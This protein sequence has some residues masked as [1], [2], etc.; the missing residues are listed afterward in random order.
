MNIWLTES[1]LDG[2]V[3]PGVPRRGEVGFDMPSEAETAYL[4][5]DLAAF[6]SDTAVFEVDL[7][8]GAQS[9]TAPAAVS[10]SDPLAVGDPVSNGEL[11]FVL[12]AVSFPPWADST[13][14]PRKGRGS[15]C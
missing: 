11:R 14:R 5:V 4:L 7:T 3:L 8:G 2:P 13:S 6:A 12:E 10:V 1:H 15:W 9:F